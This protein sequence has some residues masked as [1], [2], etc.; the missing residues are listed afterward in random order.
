M[1]L[2]LIASLLALLVGDLVA[3]NAFRV[4]ALAS[5]VLDLLL[6]GLIIDYRICLGGPTDAASGPG[7]GS[8]DR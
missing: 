3:F 8:D 2:A 7:F 6:V 5:T 4:A 1:R